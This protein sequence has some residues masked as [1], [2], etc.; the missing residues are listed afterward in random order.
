M[1]RK[2]SNMLNTNEY[3]IIGANEISNDE[4]KSLVLLYKELIGQDQV[5]TYLFLLYQ[6]RTVFNKLSSLLEAI[7]L[8]LDIFEEHI[9][10]LEGIK[11]I[12][13][14][15]NDN[16]IVF[17][18]NK[19]L[20]YS[21]LIH[22]N[23][24]GR[25]L[26][27]KVNKPYYQTL[28]SLLT[29][30][31][32]LEGFKRISSNMDISCLNKWDNKDEV[33]FTQI[34]KLRDIKDKPINSIFDI[35]NFVKNL[36]NTLFPINLRTHENLSYIAKLADIYNISEDR[37]RIFLKDV[38]SLNPLRF[39]KDKL[40]TLCLASNTENNVVNNEN[41]YL[42][43]CAS[44]IKQMQGGKDL[45]PSDKLLLERLVNDYKLKPEVINVLLEYAYNACKKQFIPKFIYAIA[46]N[47]YRNDI[48]DYNKALNLINNSEKQSKTNINRNKKDIL[49]NYDSSNNMD[50]SD[51]LINKYFK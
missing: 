36:S 9:S 12:D 32:N 14:Y 6:N 31:F 35:N 5:H 42:M 15:F 4:L 41:P 21:E 3:R 16:Q 13:T 2:G 23:I 26:M 39:N 34:D 24:F 38:I 48:N 25:L 22:H 45:T 33:I 43:P 1:V 8:S 18:L 20:N 17:V 51:D 28:L 30:Q 27:H 19:P 47:F 40:L 29:P 7:N 49:P 11:L 10:K 37:M 46:A 50:V 44:F